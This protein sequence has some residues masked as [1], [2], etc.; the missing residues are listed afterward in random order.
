[1]SRSDHNPMLR[2]NL[3]AI[4]PDSDDLQEPDFAEIA[5][6]VESSDDWREMLQARLAFDRQVGQVMRAVE[7]P[8]N[9]KDRLL[10]TT[11]TQHPSQPPASQLRVPNRR[12]LLTMAAGLML[13]LGTWLLWPSGPAP[14]TLDE[15][16]AALPMSQ[17]RLLW[18]SL[19]TFDND[20]AWQPPDRAWSDCLSQ[21]TGGFDFDRDGHDDA[22]LISFATRGRGRVSGYLLVVPAA[23]VADAPAS[24]QLSRTADSYTPLANAAWTSS[25][26][27]FVYIAFVEEGQFESLVRLLYGSSV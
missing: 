15:I 9:L 11:T 13:A 18:G 12:G 7:V 14:F 10:R 24:K 23:R 6:L 3:D 21:S 26:G 2:E 25:D 1:M 16:R 20:F 19:D 4:R 17:G 5:D 22:A 8:A 27:R